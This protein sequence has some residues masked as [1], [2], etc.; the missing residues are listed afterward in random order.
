MVSSLPLHQAHSIA[1]PRFGRLMDS[2]RKPKSLQKYVQFKQNWWIP[3]RTQSPSTKVL[4]TCHGRYRQ[5]NGCF[6]RLTCTYSSNSPLHQQKVA[7]LRLLIDLLRDQNRPWIWSDRKPG[8]SRRGETSSPSSIGSISSSQPAFCASLFQASMVPQLIVG[9][10][11]IF[12]ASHRPDSV[13]LP[14]WRWKGCGCLP[15]IWILPEFLHCRL[16]CL[17]LGSANLTNEALG[18]TFLWPNLRTTTAV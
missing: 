11:F 18:G 6:L 8:R 16:L 7:R 13:L 15:H 4:Q 9:S 12:V 5:S 10:L 2:T 17:I 3:F 14:V 1:P